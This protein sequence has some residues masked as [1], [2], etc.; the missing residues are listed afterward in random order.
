VGRWL[1][2]GGVLACDK[3]AI[4]HDV[5]SKVSSLIDA[6]TEAGEAIFQQERHH[7]RQAHTGFFT[8]GESC[9]LSPFYDGVPSAAFAKTKAAGPWQ[10]AET[11]LPS[12]SKASIK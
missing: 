8:I 7:I 1:R 3:I 4:G 11:A 2:R 9:N 12:P 5:G 6:R 10:T